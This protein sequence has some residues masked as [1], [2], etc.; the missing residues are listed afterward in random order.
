M[1]TGHPWNTTAADQGG[2]GQT[3]NVKIPNALVGTSW[4]PHGFSAA[5]PE[6]ESLV[7]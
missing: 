3:K 4:R 7:L 5:A 1:E 2:H 6:I